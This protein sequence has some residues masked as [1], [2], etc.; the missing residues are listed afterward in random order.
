VGTL[1]AS[2]RAL[3]GDEP[4]ADDAGQEQLAAL[5]AGAYGRGRTLAFACAITG[6]AAEG[7]AEWGA[8]D[9]ER[10]RRFW[11]GAIYWLTENS[12]VGRR[13]LLAELDK[14]YFRPGE[15]VTLSATAFDERA[16]PN[17]DYRVVAMVEPEGFDVT[18]D[19]APLR[20]P[21]GVER[22]GGE[23]GPLVAWGEEFELPLVAGNQP[24]LRRVVLPLAGGV[25][26]A[27][28]TLRIEVTAYTGQIQ[29]DSTSLAL[30]V[31]DDPLELRNPTPDH[32]FLTELAADSG[33]RVLA[34]S[35]ALADVLRG[36]PVATGPPE[37]RQ[38]P[39]WSNG[40]M[41]GL[42]LGL[43]TVEWSWRQRLGLA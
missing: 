28:Q 29:V 40:W 38:T 6:P 3:N 39:L 16:A 14:H 7:F 20:W 24:A 23:V 37:V 15:E 33:G 25:G 34:D 41:Y 5:V 10:Y 2:A 22:P 12:A 8:G 4:S 42:L 36:L 26:A 35:A 21:K 43:L 1:V 30:Q 27:S 31:I 32:H 9:G 18:G 13:R 17:A 11:Q 19:F